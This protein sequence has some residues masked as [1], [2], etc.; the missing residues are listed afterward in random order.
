MDQPIKTGKSSKI[1]YLHMFVFTCY[2]ETVVQ[3]SMYGLVRVLDNSKVPRS[4]Y[5][6]DFTIHAIESEL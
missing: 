5:M 6:P 2:M 4:L 1:M 3:E